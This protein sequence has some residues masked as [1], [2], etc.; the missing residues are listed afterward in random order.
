MRGR[1]TRGEPASLV[2]TCRQTQNMSLRASGPG[3]LLLPLRGN[4]PSA[5]TGVAI[6][7]FLKML[8]NGTFRM[9]I[10]TPLFAFGKNADVGH[11]FGMTENQL[12]LQSEP[13]G[14]VR[15]HVC[16]SSLFF[17]EPNL[18]L[19]RGHQRIDLFLNKFLVQFTAHYLFLYRFEAE[20]GR[21]DRG[22]PHGQ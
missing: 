3:Q 21:Y 12:C 4:S 9:R 18:S 10:P 11:W 19:F 7:S 5:H 15:F 20:N 6:R 16:F 14:S 8:K 1:G 17:S 2:S 13:H 22:S